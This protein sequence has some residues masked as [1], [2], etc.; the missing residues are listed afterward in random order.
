MITS[1]NFASAM[2]ADVGAINWDVAVIDEAHKLRNAYRAS[3]RM[4][5]RLR[6]ALAD[7]FKVLLTAT[8]LQNSLLELYGLTTVIDSRIFGE[9]P[10]FRSQY[11]NQDADLGELRARL[12]YFCKR[13]LRKQVTE[14]IQYTQ[15]N[16][17]TVPFRAS[18]EEQ[19]LYEAISQFLLRDDTYSIPQRQRVM[20]TLILRKLLASSSYAIAGTLD[21]LTLRLSKLRDGLPPDPEF[22]ELLFLHEDLE[23]EYVDESEEVSE[24]VIALAIWRLGN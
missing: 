3:N 6:D 7:K 1:I 19:R 9:V 17:V 2:Q 12:G 11:M 24:N 4:G 8:P 21:T 14:Y 22:P 10:S 13:T 18:D 23:P 16:A 5:Q 15:R 20:T